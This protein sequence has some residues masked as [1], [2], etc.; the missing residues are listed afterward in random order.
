MALVDDGLLEGGVHVFGEPAYRFRLAG[1]GQRE[2]F[3][4]P[5]GLAAGC[6]YRDPV[7]R[8]VVELRYDRE[9]K[10]VRYFADDELVGEWTLEIEPTASADLFERPSK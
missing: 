7:Y 10:R 2:V 5:D 4:F 1:D 8:H 6:R 3:L 9:G